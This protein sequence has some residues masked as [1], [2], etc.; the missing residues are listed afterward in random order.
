MPEDVTC[1]IRHC[2][3]SLGRALPASDSTNQDDPTS[4]SA[5]NDVA[6]SSKKNGEMGWAGSSTSVGSEASAM[7]EAE[8]ATSNPMV[9]YE[10][11]AISGAMPKKA[12][13]IPDALHEALKSV[14]KAPSGALTYMAV[15]AL[16]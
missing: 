14:L 11:S 5:T 7:P 16:P 2:K 13:L 1:M 15:S 3:S 8:A 6:P 12:G 4:M 9:A 10:S